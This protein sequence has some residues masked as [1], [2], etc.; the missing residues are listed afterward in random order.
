MVISRQSQRGKNLNLRLFP[1]WRIN[2]SWNRL[3]R[4]SSKF[5]DFKFP[6]VNMVIHMVTSIVYDV[7]VRRCCTNVWN[8]SPTSVTQFKD[9]LLSLV[10][11]DFLRN[12]QNCTTVK[13]R[14]SSD[15]RWTYNRQLK[16]D[17]IW[18]MN[19]ANLYGSYE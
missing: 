19:S 16:G 6:L 8:Q 13:Y 4:K 5:P 12:L 9:Q 2:L 17:W 14:D 3:L 1:V 7:G 10:D 18:L 11:I 15:I